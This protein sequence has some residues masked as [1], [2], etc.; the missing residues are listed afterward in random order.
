MKYLSIGILLSILGVLLSLFIWGIDKA[1]LITG[2]IGI[3]FIVISLLISGSM[4]SGDRMR[5][6]FATESAEDRRQRTSTTT[7]TVLIGLPNVILAALLY[8]LIN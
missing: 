1:Y 7:R 8:F 3:L 5:A 4:V 6:N 2:G